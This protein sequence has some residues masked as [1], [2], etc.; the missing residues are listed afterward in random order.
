MPKPKQVYREVY[1]AGT[2][3][4]KAE[5]LAECRI[6]WIRKGWKI[7]G[8][9]LRAAGRLDNGEEFQVFVVTTREI[10]E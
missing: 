7:T 8:I 3:S 6:P 9:E 5:K 4:V 10:S 2:M 1:R